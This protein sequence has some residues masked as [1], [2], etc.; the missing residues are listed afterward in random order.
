MLPCDLRRRELLW[1]SKIVR[2][3]TTR[4]F[5]WARLPSLMSKFPTVIFAGGFR[6]PAWESSPPRPFPTIFM[7]TFTN[8]TFRW[9]QPSQLLKG[10]FPCRPSKPSASSGRWDPSDH[11][12][13]QSSI[14]TG[15]EVTNRQY[16]EFVRTGADTRKR[17]Y[18]KEKFIQDGRELTWE[19]ATDLLRDSSGRPGPSTW[20]AGHYPAGRADYPVGGVSWYEASAYAEFAGKSLPVIAQWYWAAPSSIARYVIAQSNFSTASGPA[21]KYQG[22]GPFGT[23]D[24]A[25]SVAEW[26]RKSESWQRRR[27]LPTRRRFLI[28]RPAS[29]LAPRAI[30]YVSSRRQCRFSAACRI[31]PRYPRRPRPS[32]GSRFATFQKRSPL[33]MRSSESTKICM[34]TTARLSMRRWKASFRIRRTGARKKS[35]SMRPTGKSA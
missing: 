20:E 14:S 19:Q 31:P 28:P 21:G 6:N 1:K 25:G 2:R 33:P 24:M 26:C 11:S 13:S 30:S 15:F 3:R 8:S 27:L 22:L 17:E 4:G 32:A 35:R 7:D 29:I 10:W 23:Y 16:Q 12:I 5:R 18:W 34:L 9:M